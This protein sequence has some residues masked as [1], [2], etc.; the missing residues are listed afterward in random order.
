MK[1]ISIIMIASA[2]ILFLAS[3]VA[4]EPTYKKH[5]GFGMNQ[6]TTEIVDNIKA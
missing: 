1:K 2:I 3:C 4:G 5:D 6:S